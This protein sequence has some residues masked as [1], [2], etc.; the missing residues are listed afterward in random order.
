MVVLA[1]SPSLQWHIQS[2]CT[3]VF[4]VVAL[5]A[6][7]LLL[8]WRLCCHCLHCHPCCTGIAIVEI[9]LSTLLRWHLPW[10]R[11]R[12][13]RSCAGISS[14]HWRL[15]PCHNGVITLVVLTSLPS[16]LLSL[17]WCHQHRYAGVFA[18]DVQVL[19]P[20]LQQRC[21]HLCMV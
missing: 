20:S 3:G 4:A 10:L 1:L 14:L 13:C 5:L 16:F 2:C 12:C 21:H 17:G 6:S 7:L 18:I 15:C 8:Q 19:L 11:R 9:L